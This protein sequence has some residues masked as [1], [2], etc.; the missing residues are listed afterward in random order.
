MQDEGIKYQLLHPH[1]H[2]R[3]AADRSIQTW[4]NHFVSGLCSCDPDFPLHLWDSL[5][6]QCDMTLNM[7]RPSRIN[8][9]V[10]AYKQL[11]GIFDFSNTPL[12]LPVTRAIIY[13][14]PKKR[15]TWGVHGVDGWYLGPAMEHYRCYRVYFTDTKKIR[16][17]YTVDFRP[18]KVVIPQLYSSD[19]ILGA[20]GELI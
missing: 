14:T 2:R 12:M 20:A 17:P 5:L 19:L 4:K 10:S 1:V 11:E 9:K 3:N 18:A 8:Q 7:L 13:E 16:T 15:K 6:P